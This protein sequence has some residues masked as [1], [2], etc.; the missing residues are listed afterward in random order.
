M[1][2]R[3]QLHDGTEPSFEDT[4]PD[5]SE[6]ARQDQ[7]LFLSIGRWGVHEVQLP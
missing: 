5:V 4:I 3:Y 7:A 6:I 1:F 2:D